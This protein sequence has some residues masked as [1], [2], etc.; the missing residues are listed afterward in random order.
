MKYLRTLL[1]FALFVA[2]ATG[3]HTVRAH[4]D[5]EFEGH[6]TSVGDA[7]ITLSNGSTIQV[8]SDTSWESDGDLFSLVD[9]AS[10]LSSGEDVEVEGD[11]ADN[12]D[13]TAASIKAETDDNADDK[14][15]DSSDDSDNRSDD[16]DDDSDKSNS[17]RDRLEQHREDRVERMEDHREDMEERME[18]RKEQVEDRKEERHKRL[19]EQ[20]RNRID[21]ILNMIMNRLRAAQRRLTHIADRIASRIEKIEEETDLDLSE[22][23]GFVADANAEVDAAAEKITDLEEAIDLALDSDTPREDLRGTVRTLLDE[24]KVHFKTARNLLRQAVSSIKSQLPERD[25]LDEDSDNDSVDNVDD[26]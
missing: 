22:A 2:F 23:K 6:V 21:T 26:N 15:D 24:I 17:L 5:S 7:S 10:A 9:I 19:E 12:T 13:D 11:Y 1:M 4:E 25:A 3:A 20:L 16:N 14:D 8:N 18:D